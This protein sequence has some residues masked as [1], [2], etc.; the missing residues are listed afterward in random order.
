MREV[1]PPS[2]SLTYHYTEYSYAVLTGL[3]SFDRLPTGK[4]FWGGGEE[5]EKRGPL[6]NYSVK[7]VPGIEY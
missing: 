6:I 1:H 7:S 4:G 3:G 5:V 2:P